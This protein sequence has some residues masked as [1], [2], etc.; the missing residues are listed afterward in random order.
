MIFRCDAEN[1]T[2][3]SNLKLTF[4]LM[5]V[6]LL[7]PGLFYALHSHSAETPKKFPLTD[8]KIKTFNTLQGYL[9]RFVLVC[10]NF[11]VCFGICFWNKRRDRDHFRN[12]VAVLQ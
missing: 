7:F 5:A 4:I 12:F 1:K 10:T 9:W 8:C 2:T 3:V 11:V 6:Q